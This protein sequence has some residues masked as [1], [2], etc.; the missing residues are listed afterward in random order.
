LQCQLAAR[1]WRRLTR[2]TPRATLGGL[3][4]FKRMPLPL[5]Q[6]LSVALGMQFQRFR[7]LA[8]AAA[9]AW[10]RLGALRLLALVN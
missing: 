4:Y 9:R 7:G 3:A 2:H 6:R 1:G 8:P 5:S 10:R